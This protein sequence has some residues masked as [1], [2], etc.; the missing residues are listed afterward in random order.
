[1][2]AVYCTFTV[3]GLNYHRYVIDKQFCLRLFGNIIF[4]SEIRY[5]SRISVRISYAFFQRI[6]M[7]KI[8]F[9]ET[10]LRAKNLISTLLHESCW[11]ACVIL[12]VTSFCL[13][14]NHHSFLDWILYFNLL[15]LVAQRTQRPILSSGCSSCTKTE[16]IP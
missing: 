13:T 7:K 1:V 5:P 8:V 2:T 6:E 15:L 4:V 10:V 3:G 11:C 14:L 12:M 9:L 16:A